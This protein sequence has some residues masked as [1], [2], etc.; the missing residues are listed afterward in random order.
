MSRQTVKDQQAAEDKARDEAYAKRTNEVQERETELCQL[1]GCTWENSLNGRKVIQGAF[2]KKVAEVEKAAEGKA[3]GIAK[4][5]FEQEKKLDI[6]NNQAA[7]ALL[8]QKNAQF[9]VQ[10]K[11]LTEQNAKLL[12]AAES[13]VSGMKDLAAKGFEAAGAINGR[14]ASALETAASAGF[15]Q[16]RGRG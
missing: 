11:T 5:E 16:P 13:Q 9:E 14:G 2:L 15:G 4:R 7:L 12:L 1:L 8:N 10:V 6:A 3:A